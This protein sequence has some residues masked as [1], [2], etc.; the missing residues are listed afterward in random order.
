MQALIFAITFKLTILPNVRIGDI[1]HID[2]LSF[3]MKLVNLLSMFSIILTIKDIKFG[4]KSYSL[5]CGFIKK[6]HFIS[7]VI[8]KK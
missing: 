7:L 4:V 6:F 1:D 2:F 3:S 5:V 8:P